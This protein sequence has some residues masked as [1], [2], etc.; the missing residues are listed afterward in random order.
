MK[1]A[2]LLLILVM[3]PV[4]LART[5]EVELKQ[6]E[7]YSFDG[8]NITLMKLDKSDERVVICVNNKKEIV[9]ENKYIE[10]I[11][12]DL[13][14]VK[15][16]SAKFEFRFSECEE[17]NYRS[18]DNLDCFDEC[19]V[20]L[21]CDDSNENTVDRCDGKPR[22]CINTEIKKEEEKKEEEKTEEEKEEVVKE[23]KREFKSFTQWVYEAIL[24]LFSKLTE[25]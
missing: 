20:D 23:E 13:K 10:G 11:N 16:D 24:S 7:S 25:F 15:E 19:S 9:S 2:I 6:G 3:M 21:D 18:W 1:K 14:W 12:I 4:A 5:E 22:K 8:R 17:C